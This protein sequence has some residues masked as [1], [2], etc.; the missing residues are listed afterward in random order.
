MTNIQALILAA[1]KGVRIGAQNIPKVL[2]PLLDKPMILY[3][4]KTMQKAGFKKPVLVIG[5]KGEKVK[6]LL[7]EGVSYVWQKEQL[8]T[9]HAVLKAEKTLKGIKSVLIIYGDTP[10]WK[11]ETFKK[12]IKEHKKNNATL[13]LVSVILEN[14]SFFRYGRI[15]RDRKGELQAI[16]EEKDAT[17]EQKK[18]K[19]CNPGC[20]LIETKWLF[21]N[22]PKI[23]KSP[24]SGEYYLTDILGLAVS[25]GEKITVLPIKDWRQAIGIN[26]QEQLKM[27]EKILEKSAKI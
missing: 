6:K 23:E 8:G 21:E 10:L 24:V 2:F 25:Q 15:V 20:Y 12:L 14:P 26:T 9:G 17:K 5:F 1:G 11:A 13:S 27:A 16:I 19:E 3:S 18:I 4:L 7:G 22:L